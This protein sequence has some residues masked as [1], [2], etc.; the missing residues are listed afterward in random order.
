M[1]LKLG[2]KTTRKYLTAYQVRNRSSRRP[3]YIR[4]E[5]VSET[6]HETR[7]TDYSTALYKY[8]YNASLTHCQ[9]L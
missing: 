4:N 6:T 5:V 7:N 9:P 3:H 2:D 1:Q 8:L